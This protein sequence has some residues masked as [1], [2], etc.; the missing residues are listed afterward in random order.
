MVE[1]VKLTVEEIAEQ[2]ELYVMIASNGETILTRSINI[3]GEAFAGLQVVYALRAEADSIE[4]RV[5]K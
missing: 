4:A 1:E 5:F 3:D 2:A